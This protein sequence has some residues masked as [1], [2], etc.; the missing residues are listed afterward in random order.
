MKKTQSGINS[1]IKM[2]VEKDGSKTI[3]KKYKDND[4]ER[5]KRE[6]D[7]L[8]EMSRR[9]VM[10]VPVL[11]KVDEEQGWVKMTH[12]EG[13]KI[14]IIDKGSA[15]A[16]INFL[17]LINQDK[18]YRKI[19]HA[20]DA[21][22][23]IK[24]I[25]ED[26]KRRERI[27]QNKKR[28]RV[29]GNFNK[30]VQEK[31]IKEV[32]KKL[33]AIESSN[34]WKTKKEELILSPSDIGIHNMLKSGNEYYFIDFEYAGLDNP[35][36]TILDLLCQPNHNINKE[37][38]DFII[39]NIEGLVTNKGQNWIK[40]LKEMKSIMKIKWCFIMMNNIEKIDLTKE[41]EIASYYG[42]L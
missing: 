36:K 29:S 3:I 34:F 35:N 20:R 22:L 38:E 2:M 27:Y 31:L 32:G 28:Q 33:E 37:L 19:G 4:Q 40:E 10:N 24:Y 1:S 5:R 39:T 30:W 9:E 8:K 12:I 14:N 23:S 42:K 17:K 6:I 13:K 41:E 15:N 16:I 21:Y 25:K 26:I 18:D 7:F 11:L